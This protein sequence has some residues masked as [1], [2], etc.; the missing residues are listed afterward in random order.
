MIIAHGQFISDTEMHE[1]RRESTGRFGTHLSAHI[2]TRENTENVRQ[3]I[4]MSG[5]VWGRTK[6]TERMQT[7]SNARERVQVRTDQRERARGCGKVCVRVEMRGN[8]RESKG[9]MEH[10]ITRERT[11]R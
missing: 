1:N 4:A 2:E 5:N 9:N 6:S 10:K 3:C 7:R 11:E 8:I